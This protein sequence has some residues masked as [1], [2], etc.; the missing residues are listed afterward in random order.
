LHPVDMYPPSLKIDE[1]IK[2]PIVTTAKQLSGK[3]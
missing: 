1:D 3:V 2:F